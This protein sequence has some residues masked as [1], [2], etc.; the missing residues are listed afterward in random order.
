VCRSGG[1]LCVGTV[2]GVVA[3]SVAVDLVFCSGVRQKTIK[4]K[5]CYVQ[6]LNSFTLS[7]YA[8]LR[9]Q[10]KGV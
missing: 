3:V 5:S 10:F 6:R 9:S 4:L 1:H 8:V 2:L 7:L